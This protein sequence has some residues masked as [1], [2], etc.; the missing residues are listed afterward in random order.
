MSTKPALTSFNQVAPLI[1][2]SYQRY[3]PTAFSD[4]LSILEKVNKVI[5]QLH[6]I[7]EISNGVV[8]QWNEVMEW[9][10]NDGL[11]ETIAIRLDKMVQDGTFDTIINDELLNEK[12]TI[13]VSSVEPIEQGDKSFWFE[14][15]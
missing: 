8:D 12:A 2:Q 11:S 15:I 10:M 6:Q 5:E 9:V 7:G 4:D 14:I 3:L 1:I 13:V